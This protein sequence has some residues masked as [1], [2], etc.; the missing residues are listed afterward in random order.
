MSIKFVEY[1]PCSKCWYTL[2]G[3]TETQLHIAKIGEISVLEVTA[4][5]IYL[6]C[7]HIQDQRI[8]IREIREN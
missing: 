5:W 4:T 1:I 2:I 3:E 8:N 7:Q 6:K